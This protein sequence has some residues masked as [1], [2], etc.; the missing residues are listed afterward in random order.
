M[1]LGQ[2]AN[3]LSLLVMPLLLTGLLNRVKSLWSGRKGPP[4]LQ[5]AYDVLRLLRK[6]PVYSTTTT[7][8]FQIAPWVFLLTAFGSALLV[9][10]LGSRAIASFPFDFVWF[11][12]VWALGRVAVML[13]ALDT[14]SAFEGMGSARE[15]T[16]STLLEP[17]LF[18]VLSA[19]CLRSG[20]HTLEEA[21]RLDVANGS[22]LIRACAVLALLIVLQV[23]SARMPV[24]DPSTHLELTMVHE[25]MVL[26]HS[27]PDLAAIQL[28]SAIKLFVGASMI[29][30]LLN[31]WAASGGPAASAANLALAA[32]VA[33]FVGTVESLVAR[34]KLR[35]VPNYIAI[36]LGSAAVALLLGAWGA[37]HGP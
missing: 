7:P 14:G 9:P 16:F 28:G 18:L 25:V 15:A 17:V 5:P 30:T 12:Y 35:L 4:L 20:T 8:L 11:A 26:D 27:G 3:V 22:L 6:T 21:L 36:A 32:L 10:V 33:V 34:L 2:L 29:A 31:P 24:D 19:L 1:I 23:E 37:V 13:A